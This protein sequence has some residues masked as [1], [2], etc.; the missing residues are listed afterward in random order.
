MRVRGLVMRLLAAAWC[1]ALLA[2][3]QGPDPQAAESKPAGNPA[4]T[5]VGSEVCQACHEDLFNAIKK[6]PHGGVETD[7]R[8]GWD[9][10]TCESCHGPGSAHA[11]SGSAEEIR[12]PAK[13]TPTEVDKTCL[14]C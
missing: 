11:E 7:K 13:L 2:F 4:K 10:K 1:T 12:N 5:Y 6:G 9:G 14:T 3:G 8:R